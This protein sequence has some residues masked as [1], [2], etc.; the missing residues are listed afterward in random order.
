MGGRFVPAFGVKWPTNVHYAQTLS[1]VGKLVTVGQ[2]ASFI[3]ITVAKR[4]SAV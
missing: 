4:K 1:N 2:T 3:L